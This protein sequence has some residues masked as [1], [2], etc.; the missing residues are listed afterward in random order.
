MQEG[1]II[2]GIGG[3]YYVETANDNVIECKARGK[4]RKENISPIVG[5]KVKIELLDDE[6]GVIVEINPRKN[7]LIR[8]VVANVDQAIVVFSL[9]NPDLS[10]TLLDKLLLFIEHHGVEAIICLNKTDLDEKNN[11]AKVKEIYERIG[12]KV[13]KTNGR[14]GEGIDTLKELLKNKI[15]VF[16]G[17][18]GVGKSTIFN[19]VQNKVKMETS[20]TSK[21]IGRGRHTTRH[22]ELIE[23]EKNT[24]VVD[25]PGFS[26]IDLGFL[27]PDELQY[28]FKEFRDYFGKCK[29]SSCIHNKE[30]GCSIKHAVN[31]GLI[32]S[33]RYNAYVEI[34]KELNE[35]RRTRK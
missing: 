21:K 15:S 10:F 6:H 18:S 5:D 12:Y 23:I 26:S 2:K 7:Q 1:I 25:T 20:E 22:A 13:I 29:F 3:F 16:A 35:N 17:P 24:F 9:K 19:K 8:P 27:D 30:I 11:F 31:T 32:S 14:T 34:L 4:F 28:T 33:E